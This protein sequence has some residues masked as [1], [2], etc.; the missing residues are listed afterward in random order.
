[1]YLPAQT[2]KSGQDEVLICPAKSNATK[3]GLIN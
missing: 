2:H 3:A 1:M